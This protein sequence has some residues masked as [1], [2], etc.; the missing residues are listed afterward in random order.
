MEGPLDGE[1][2]YL[3]FCFE[4]CYTGNVN[5]T[6]SGIMQA[7]SFSEG[8]HANFY[9]YEGKYNR[10][11]VKYEVYLTNDISKT[12]K[13]TVTVTYLYDE[14]ALTPVNKPDFKPALNVFQE[15]SRVQFNYAFDSSVYQLEIYNLTGQKMAQHLLTSGAGTFTLSER[16]TK[17]IYLC[18]I[19]NKNQ[20]I[21]TQKFIVK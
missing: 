18:V 9:V 2:G 15:G 7:N 4:N 5:R 14:N 10:I 20:T 17:G 12:D 6:M 8:Y 16:L 1:T 13:K 21:A 11:K 19:K 3:S